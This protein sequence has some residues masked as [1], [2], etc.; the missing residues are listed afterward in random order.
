MILQV[1]HI[2]IAHSVFNQAMMNAI[3]EGSGHQLKIEAPFVNVSK[4]EVVRI[5]LDWEF[6]TS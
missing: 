4:A 2:R 6:L 5:G 3:W 1:L